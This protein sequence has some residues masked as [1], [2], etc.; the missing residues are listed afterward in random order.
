MMILKF[1]RSLIKKKI[2]QLYYEQK[3]IMEDMEFWSIPRMSSAPPKVTYGYTMRNLV[4]KICDMK[5]VILE[6]IL[7]EGK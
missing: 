4:L 1:I 6:A 7:G 2:K 5:I 3:M